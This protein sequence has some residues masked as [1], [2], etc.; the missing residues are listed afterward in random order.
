MN[1]KTVALTEINPAAYNPRKD[2][3]PGDAEYEKL[4]RSIQEFDVVEPLVWNERTG[5]LVG[6]HQRLKVLKELGFAEVEVSVVD[7]DDAREK[8]LNIALNK[9]SGEWDFPALK[10][11]L[12]ELDGMIDL[13]L[14][15]FDI[16]EIESLTDKFDIDEIGAPTLADGDRTP[17]QQMAF[18]L[19]DEQAEKVKEALSFAKSRGGGESAMNENSNGNALYFICEAFING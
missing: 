17:Y 11:L 13:E 3:Q 1:I 2:L 12:E 15:G 18:T 5:N 10:D 19:H 4:K 9:I 8:A 6:G 16:D 7:M 14:T